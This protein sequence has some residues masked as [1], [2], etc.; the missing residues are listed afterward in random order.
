MSAYDWL[1]LFLYFFI[2]AAGAASMAYMSR[3]LVR[4]YLRR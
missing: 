1:I 3:R 4:R 2:P